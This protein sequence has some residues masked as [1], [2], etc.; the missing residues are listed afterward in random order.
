MPKRKNKSKSGGSSSSSSGGSKTKKRK[1]I[2]KDSSK[3]R[4]REVV[5]D[6]FYNL[7]GGKAK[8]LEKVTL[9]EHTTATTSYNV[10]KGLLACANIPETKPL[11][12][13]IHM[14]HEMAA[15]LAAGKRN[16][17]GLIL[18]TQGY[19]SKFVFNN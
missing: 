16:A 9:L 4:R 8:F 14:V 5:V 1:M 11:S 17:G 18:T 19:L 7:G 13:G 15:N 6:A 12:G 3:A 10:T 2:S